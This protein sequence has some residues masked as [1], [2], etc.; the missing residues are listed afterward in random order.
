M[1]QSR[2]SA[3]GPLLTLARIN[4]EDT[5]RVIA[6]IKF[7]GDHWDKSFAVTAKSQRGDQ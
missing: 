1:S 4:F 6:L 5:L 2:M 7:I 3:F